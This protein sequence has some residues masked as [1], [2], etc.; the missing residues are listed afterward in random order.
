MALT[1][2]PIVELVK[3]FVELAVFATAGGGEGGLGG[4]VKAMKIFP[5]KSMI[6]TTFVCWFV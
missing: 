2:L 4:F 3:I 5:K 1:A 6:S